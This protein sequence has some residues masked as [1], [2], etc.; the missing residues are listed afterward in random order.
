MKQISKEFLTSIEILTINL[1]SILYNNLIFD[2]IY[3]Q[4]ELIEDESHLR[5]EEN[6]RE[7]YDIEVSRREYRKTRVQFNRLIKTKFVR[8][9]ILIAQPIR[10]QMLFNP[11]HA[12]LYLF[13]RHL[14]TFTWPG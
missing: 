11:V 4:Y 6:P 14:S 10:K 8:R 5:N 3:I 9:T 13:Q 7:T 12:T 1:N 2:I